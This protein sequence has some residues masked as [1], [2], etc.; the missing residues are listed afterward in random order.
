MCDYC[1]HRVVSHEAFSRLLEARHVLSRSEFAIGTVAAVH[2]NEAT[3][4]PYF[5]KSRCSHCDLEMVG[6]GVPCTTQWIEFFIVEKDTHLPICD[7]CAELLATQELR[8][9]L[10]ALRRE[11]DG[12]VSLKRGASVSRG[13]SFRPGGENFFR[14]IRLIRLFRRR[15]R[16]SERLS[17]KLS[18]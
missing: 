4:Q 6:G 10:N 5:A 14:L 11:R 9:L 17:Q 16:A 18:H 12:V 15:L 3:N 1:A 8:E 13:L 2:W 7:V